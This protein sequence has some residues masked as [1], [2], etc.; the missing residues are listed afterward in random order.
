M[1]TFENRFTYLPSVK[2]QPVQQQ[3][4]ITTALLSSLFHKCCIITHGFG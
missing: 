3:K 2:S 1:K 4:K